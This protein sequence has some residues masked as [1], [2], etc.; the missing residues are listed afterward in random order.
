[1]TIIV[2]LVIFEFLNSILARVEIGQR[3]V[4]FVLPYRQ[5]LLPTLFYRKREIMFTDIER[6]EKRREIYGG[7]FAPV[8]MQ[9]AVII[10]KD[11]GAYSLGYVSEADLDP[12][13]PVPEIANE[14]ARRANVDIVD[15][16][17]VHR[18]ATPKT[19]GLKTRR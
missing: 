17:A 1:M 19:A 10:T 8:M 18:P 12:L 5:A 6:I 7:R 3:G 4:R 16:G 9:G 13:F 14:I 2:L 11:G 15:K